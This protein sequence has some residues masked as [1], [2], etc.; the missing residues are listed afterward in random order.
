VR[1]RLI[2]LLPRSAHI[3]TSVSWQTQKAN[4]A[5]ARFP[6]LIVPSGENV[7]LLILRLGARCIWLGFAA[8]LQKVACHI[9][10]R[11]APSQRNPNTPSP[12]TCSRHINQVFEA[13]TP[14]NNPK[15]PIEAIFSHRAL[16]SLPLPPP[17]TCHVTFLLSPIV[18]W[19]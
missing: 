5:L 14:S 3:W 8:V 1:Y 11:T 13:H 19:L 10:Y 7:L 9:Y 12:Y 17:A 15:G 18:R 2:I 6:H 16:N 4:Q